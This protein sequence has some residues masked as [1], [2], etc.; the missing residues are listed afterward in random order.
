MNIERS[1][2]SYICIFYFSQPSKSVRSITL[3][4]VLGVLVGIFLVTTIVFGT[5]YSFEKSRTTTATTIMTT[6]TASSSSPTTT[7]KLSSPTT[8][9][10]TSLTT[11]PKGIVLVLK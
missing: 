3:P 2:T 5:L 6:T 8:I 4:R 11:T 7:S 1:G 10:S 9:T